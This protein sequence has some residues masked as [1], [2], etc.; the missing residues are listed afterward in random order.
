MAAAA[1]L[2]FTQSAQAQIP[3]TDVASLTQQVQQVLAW[4]QQASQMVQQYQK[5]SEQLNAIRGTRGMGQ[6]LNTPQARQ[7]LPDGFLGQFDKLR[8]LGV[9]GASSDARAIYESIRTFDCAAQFPNNQQSRL[10]CE[11][12]A[13]VHPTNLALIGRS[14]SSS[15][16]RMTQLQGLMSAIDSADDTKAA[17]DL[18]N[19]INVEMALLQNE[20]MM[21]DMALAQQEREAKL[22]K[23][24]KKEA[25]V[26]RLTDPGVNPFAQP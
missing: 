20:K 8:S 6:L 15:Q 18:S 11:A 2:V 3:V 5:M 7:Q 19:R 16:A 13:M 17:Q 4:S 23:Q 22:L 14:I 12:G 21:M 26:K 9:G 10:S 24:Q 1:W 25:G